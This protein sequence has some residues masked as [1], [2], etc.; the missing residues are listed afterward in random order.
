[1]WAKHD[2]HGPLE[3]LGNLEGSLQIWSTKSLWHTGTTPVSKQCSRSMGW[4][5]SPSIGFPPILGFTLRLAP[6]I[7]C[8]IAW[9]V[10]AVPR[11]PLGMPLELRE[12]FLCETGVVLIPLSYIVETCLCVRVQGERKKGRWRARRTANKKSTWEMRMKRAEA[13]VRTQ[14]PCS[15][16]S[17]AK[18]RSLANNKT[19]KKRQKRDWKVTKNET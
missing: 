10:S 6:A 19:N 4:N 5:A 15:K 9:V 18:E 7:G 16:W 1:M 12:P 17:L 14:S 13:D 2:A 8:R 11:V 3:D